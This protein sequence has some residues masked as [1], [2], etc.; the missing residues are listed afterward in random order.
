MASEFLYWDDLFD[1]PVKIA[2]Q[3]RQAGSVEDFY[4][5][6]TTQAIP[7]LRVKTALHGWRVLLSSAI[8]SIESD[9]V[10]VANEQML[11]DEANAGHL[12]QLP[13]GHQLIGYRLVSERGR[14]IGT[15][16]NL[17]LGIVPPAA[18]RISALEIGRRHGRRISAHAITAIGNGTLTIIEQ[19]GI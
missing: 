18:L 6:P 4:Y 7:A 5:D 14:E 9:G 16:S 12:S 3:G 19:E 11:I 15:V 1:S 10:T 13:L 2:G 8:E 17:L